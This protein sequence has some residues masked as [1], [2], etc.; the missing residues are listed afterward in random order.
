MENRVFFIPWFWDKGT[1]LTST[2]H[3]LWPHGGKNGTNKPVLNRQPTADEL[4]NVENSKNSAKIPI[5]A[6]LNLNRQPMA[7]NLDFSEFCNSQNI[8]ECAWQFF[9][10]YLI[11]NTVCSR[12]NLKDFSGWVMSWMNSSLISRMF[13]SMRLWNVLVAHN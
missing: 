7:G 12:L 10:L 2:G 1:S 4:E 8:D 6:L 11:A 9:L 5:F 13:L 3:K